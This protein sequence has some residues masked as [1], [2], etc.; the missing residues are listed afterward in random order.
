MAVRWTL[1]Q[2]HHNFVDFHPVGRPALRYIRLQTGVV[3]YALRYVECDREQEVV[4]HLGFDDKV[5]VRVNDQ[6]VFRG[7]HQ[8][9]FREAQFKAQLKRGR[10]RLLVKL[11]NEANTTWRVWAFSFR[12]EPVG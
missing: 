6:E 2:A 7:E 11:S 4:V 8:E 3:G 9:G 5:A 1:Q 12:M 10:N